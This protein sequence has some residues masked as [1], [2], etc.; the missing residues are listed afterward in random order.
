MS[1]LLWAIWGLA[2]AF[3]FAC[4]S[5]ITQLFDPPGGFPRTLRASIEFFF[6]LSLGPIGGAGV[7][8]YLASA[9]L[10]LNSEPECRA[11]A[12]LIGLIVN[13]VAPMA[14]ELWTNFSSG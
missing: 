7:G 8:P 6:A 5:L 13:P 1:T 14:V 11:L 4:P 2:G 10:H 9:F 12:V 3:V